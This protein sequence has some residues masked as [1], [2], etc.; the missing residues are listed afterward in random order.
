M[1]RLVPLTGDI[2]RGTFRHL[3]ADVC[4]PASPPPLALLAVTSEPSA[5]ARRALFRRLYAHAAAAA[6]L[7]LVFLLGADEPVARAFNQFSD[8]S[9]AA[10]GGSGGAAADAGADPQ[11][12]RATQAAVD[13]E[14]ARHGDII[15]SAVPEHYFHLGLKTVALL[16]AFVR[17]CAGARFLVKT[18]DDVLVNIALLAAET[19]ALPAE[20]AVYG[21]PA[22]SLRPDRPGLAWQGYVSSRREWPADTYPPLVLGNGYLVAA[23]AAAPLL[24]AA[25]AARYHHLEDV[26]VTG[27]AAEAAG[28][29]RR[30]WSRH[31]IHSGGGVPDVCSAARCALTHRVNYGRHADRLEALLYA[32]VRLDVDTLCAANRTRRLG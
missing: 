27:V 13:T 14:A 24:R 30:P 16:D 15:Q 4:A 11:R 2:Y 6:R 8:V 7:R 9:D 5:G 3:P 22:A 29:P 1:D 26:F 23:A 28:V 12:R 10:A 31:C 25:L 20:R 32:T 18:D 17:V 19:A 21:R